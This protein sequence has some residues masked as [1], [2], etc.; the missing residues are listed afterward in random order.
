MKRFYAYLLL[1]MTSLFCL[2]GC[3]SRTAVTVHPETVVEQH[4]KALAAGDIEHA[5]KLVYIPE[6]IPN[7]VAYR[8][9]IH[10]ILERDKQELDSR[11]IFQYLTIKDVLTRF[12]NGDIK[13]GQPE[14]I[15]R[16]DAGK[17]TTAIVTAM[18]VFQNG[19]YKEAI[20]PLKHTGETY[21]IVITG[22][23][24]N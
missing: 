23:P 12:T 1:V 3:S 8:Q 18:I 17:G 5:A 10:E 16:N 9:K 13:N 20:Y 14:F 21:R 15:K 4:I 24:E 7:P 22:M 11:G 2:A 19:S 6:N